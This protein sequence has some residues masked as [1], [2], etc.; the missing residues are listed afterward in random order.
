[1][2][3]L[4][5]FVAGFVFASAPGGSAAEQP[6]PEQALPSVMALLWQA[7]EDATHVP[8]PRFTPELLGRITQEIQADAE[9]GEA[10]SRILAAADGRYSP[11]PWD[12]LEERHA[13]GSLTAIAWLDGSFR[14]AALDKLLRLGDP[15]VLPDIASLAESLPDII[16]GSEG[17]TLHANDVAHVRLALARLSGASLTDQ[18]V[19]LVEAAREARGVHHASPLTPIEL[20]RRA[21]SGRPCGWVPCDRA[22]WAFLNTL[23]RAYGARLAR[24]PVVNG[25]A[26]FF[27]AEDLATLDELMLHWNPVGWTRA[28]IE[29]VLGEPGRITEDV[30][31]Y[32]WVTP[33]SGGGLRIRV[34]ESGSAT[35]VERLI[36]S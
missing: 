29:R 33:R 15:S 21:L 3:I 7:Q 36:G 4:A 28:E 8:G 12:V 17:A 30:I 18:R 10:L 26:G 32:L 2:K 9:V 22:K 31:E 35:A 27:A 13:V 24:R 16:G 1:M 25:D 11:R 14:Y 19:P 5:V 34:K 20:A 6:D 23:H